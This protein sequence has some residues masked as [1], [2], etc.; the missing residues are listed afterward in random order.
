M[1]KA[2]LIT[3]VSLFAVIAVLVGVVVAFPA[4]R[5]FATQALQS[6]SQAVRAAAPQPV[7]G[8]DLSGTGAGSLVSATTMPAVKGLPR[9]VRAARVVYR[10]TNGDTNEPTEVSGS[11][12][13]P[14]GDPPPGGWPVV[15]FGHGTTGLDE[16]C[17]PSLSDTLLGMVTFVDAFA[18]RGFAVAF[19]DY[20]GLGNPGVHPYTDARTAGLNM[21]DAVRALRHTHPGEISDKW[22]AFGGSQGGGAAWAAAEQAGP[23]AS[24]LNLVGAVALA[25]A[26][27]VSGLV[28]KAGEGTMTRDQLRRWR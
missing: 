19:T 18:K 22:A 13:L 26:A 6:D 20:Q 10:S 21:I 24:D 3:A 11:V 15:S 12:F 8:A 23:Y 17:A 4:F 16:P 5:D 14:A 25:P 28:T 9:G 27:D 7:A 2:L 1:R